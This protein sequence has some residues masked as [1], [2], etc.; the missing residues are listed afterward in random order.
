MQHSQHADP[1]RLSFPC[2]SFAGILYGYAVAYVQWK[3]LLAKRMR[4][5]GSAICRTLSLTFSSFVL[6]DL[7]Y[8]H[9]SEGFVI[10][11]T[12]D[13][14]FRSEFRVDNSIGHVRVDSLLP[15]MMIVMKPY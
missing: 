13:A 2:I 1:Y 3:E 10:F 5:R 4:N 7:L 6:H 8:N 12:L 9:L 14:L 15:L 11:D